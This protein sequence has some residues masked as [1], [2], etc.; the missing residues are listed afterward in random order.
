MNRDKLKK[1]AY[2][3][4]IALAIIFPLVLLMVRSFY[5]IITIT[6]IFIVPM[7]LII[8]LSILLQNRL[9]Y[10]LNAYPVLLIIDNVF[11][12]QSTNGMSF[13]FFFSYALI[14]FYF[15][16]IDQRKYALAS[17]T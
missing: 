15:S 5:A 2:I 11:K 13:Y 4:H 8:M 16:W 7:L 9:L 3:L 6:N 12:T 10:A 1:I 17:L 14:T